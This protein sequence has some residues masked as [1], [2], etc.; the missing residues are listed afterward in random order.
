[1][2]VSLKLLVL[3]CTNS[4]HFT[5]QSW[6][7]T[8]GISSPKTDVLF[9][10][11]DECLNYSFCCFYFLTVFS[12][13]ML[14]SSLCLHRCTVPNVTSGWVEVSSDGQA[15]YH[16][17]KDKLKYADRQLFFSDFYSRGCWWMPFCCQVLIWWGDSPC[18][19]VQ[20]SRRSAT[21]EDP[22]SSAWA[23]L[24]SYA[25]PSKFTI[26]L[27]PHLLSF[28]HLHTNTSHTNTSCTTLGGR[29]CITGRE[30]KC[31]FCWILSFLQ[32]YID[33]HSLYMLKK[34]KGRGT[35]HPT[36]NQP[37]NPHSSCQ[38]CPMAIV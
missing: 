26:L 25:P 22:S 19:R 24:H 33:R 16:W 6:K 1:M 4:V 29:E 10:T 5:Q 37:L 8:F 27:F 7:V 20:M 32:G 17:W 28:Q 2:Y 23:R 9:L 30:I 11:S 15:Q 31:V 35:E 34:R 36:G 38:H 3:S 13:I 12:C 18:S 21:L 14:M